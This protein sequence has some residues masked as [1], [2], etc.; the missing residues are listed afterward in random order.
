VPPRKG[1]SVEPPELPE[2]ERRLRF[3]ALQLAGLALIVLIPVLAAFEV[4]GQGTARAAGRG[5]VLSI[6][7]EYPAR[8]RHGTPEEI[9]VLATN[10]GP[11]RLDTV[12]VRFDSSYVSRFTD[13]QFVPA[14]SD[15]YEVDLVD[16]A[17]GETRVIRLGMRANEY[18]RHRGAIAVLHGA[19]TARA[20][21]STIVFP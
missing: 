20:K 1:P 10:R 13:P 7:A 21:V 19:D 8:I 3:G 16:V 14:T 17:P 4:F 9:T 5:A 18:G 12:T 6:S 2:I 15:A 11:S